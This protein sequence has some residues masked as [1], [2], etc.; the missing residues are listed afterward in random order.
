VD[1]ADIQRSVADWGRIWPRPPSWRG[2]PCQ[3]FPSDL[4]RYAEIVHELCP[5]WVLECGTAGGGTALF[6]ADACQAAGAGHVISVDN[7]PRTPDITHPRLTLLKGDTTDEGSTLARVLHLTGTWPGSSV[8]PGDRGL[9]LLDADH[10]A[11]HVLAELELYAPLAAYLICEDTL[12]EHLPGYGWG[13]HQA[14]EKWL[15]QHPEF[16]PDPE[17]V[18]SNHPGG[19]LRRR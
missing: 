1:P 2:F 15:P 8:P 19:W 12:M 10:S 16:T 4:W 9:V 6:L 17:P 5:P 3:Q 7:D 14:L 11:A 18:P 13:P